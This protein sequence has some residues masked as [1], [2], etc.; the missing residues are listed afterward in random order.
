[1]TLSPRHTEVLRLIC[2]EWTNE[3]IAQKFGVSIK[4][5]EKHRAALN[6]KFGAHSPIQLIR[7]AMREDERVLGWLRE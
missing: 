4:T 3:M 1:M 6:R 7:A 5:V 2:R